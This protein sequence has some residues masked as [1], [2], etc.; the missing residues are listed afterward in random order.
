MTASFVAAM[1]ASSILQAKTCHSQSAGVAINDC[2]A[3]ES[4]YRPT[5]IKLS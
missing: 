5:V 3:A 2:K 4:G 1:T